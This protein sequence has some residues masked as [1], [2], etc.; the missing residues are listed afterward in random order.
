MN[1]AKPG[2]TSTVWPNAYYINKDDVISYETIKG[3]EISITAK[4]IKLI[5]PTNIRAKKILFTI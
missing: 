4:T 2:K 5:S 3:S 1:T